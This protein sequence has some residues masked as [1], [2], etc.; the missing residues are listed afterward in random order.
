FSPQGR[1]IRPERHRIYGFGRDVT[2]GQRRIR[3]TTNA[4]KDLSIGPLPLRPNLIQ[5][6]AKNSRGRD[7]SASIHPDR[8]PHYI[9]S[10]RV[11]REAGAYHIAQSECIDTPRYNND[12][13][14]T[15][16]L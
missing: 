9:D 3:M 6:R 7:E 4:N 11:R 14:D 5:V 15:R 13:R 2:T 12:L 10:P 16:E 8:W 1:N